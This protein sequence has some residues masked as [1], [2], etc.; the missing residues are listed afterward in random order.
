MAENKKVRQISPDLIPVTNENKKTGA[1]GF[2][3]V[4][5]GIGVIIATFA[6]GG[7][8][9][10]YCNLQQIIVG[11]LLGTMFL[12]LL[13][14]VTGDIGVE[15]GVSF[16]TYVAALLG[17]KGTILPNLL[18]T[19][20][21]P[22]WF[23]VQSYFGATAINQIIYMFTGFDNWIIWFVVFVLVQMINTAYGF[24]A[25][26]KFA[27]IAAPSIILIGIYMAI[28]LIAMAD[29]NGVQIWSIVY[30]GDGPKLSAGSFAAFWYVSVL[31]MNYWA[32]NACE[33]ETWSRY[34]KT[35]SGEKNL[36]KRNIKAIPGY[37]IALPLASGFMVFLGALSTF[38]TGNYNP[39]E[40]INAVTNNPIVLM[41]LLIM[42][43]FAQWS[44][45]VTAN[46]MPSGLCLNALSKNKIPYWF[47][48][49]ICSI[50]GMVIRPWVLVDHIGP[51][52]TV[53]GSLWSTMYGMTIADF[54]LLRKRKLNVPE[55][56]NTDENGQ[57]QYFK[58]INPA[59]ALS[60]IIGLI[61]CIIFPDSAFI[62]GTISSCISY[63]ILAKFW[64]FK[65]YPQ[66]D[67]E[68]QG[69]AYRGTSAGRDWAYNPETGE[70]Y[71]TK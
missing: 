51:F 59:G 14:I 69:T 46:L 48:I 26:E 56:Y 40:A 32:D 33:V 15:H 68:D 70:V 44:T 6:I 27:D 57:Y 13:Y 65:K 39:I 5:I 28:R 3:N 67:Y 66:A 50:L 20:Y 45:N 64:V 1:L 7:E 19:I 29:A 30:T 36:L 55:L 11:A 52:L 63:Y 10:A 34:V 35:V 21:G 12:G 9:A 23:G 53:T 43:V 17:Q 24:K 18:R 47:A 60:F 38:A 25:M 61:F 62:V 54:F 37:V 4:W 41:V 71:P 31:N 2:F 8:A 42:I 22:I 49:V 58:G 16:P